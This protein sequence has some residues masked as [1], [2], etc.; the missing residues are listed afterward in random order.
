M[1]GLTLKNEYSEN[2][3]NDYNTLAKTLKG[4]FMNITT[5]WADV[6]GESQL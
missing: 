3:W 6:A 5:S 1:S 4:N 2:N